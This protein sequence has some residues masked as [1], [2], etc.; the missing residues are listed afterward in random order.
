MESSG[1]TQPKPTSAISLRVE[2]E[3]QGRAYMEISD[4][5]HLARRS[6]ERDDAV[7]VVASSLSKLEKAGRQPD[8]WEREALAEAIGAIFRGAYVLA[9]VNARCLVPAFDGLAR[10]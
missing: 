3:E 7:A 9:S 10:A 8:Y 2:C 4:Q 5:A 6:K 1:G